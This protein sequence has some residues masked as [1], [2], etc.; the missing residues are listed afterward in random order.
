LIWDRP[1]ADCL[2][3]PVITRFRA[4]MPVPKK[5]IYTGIGSCALLVLLIVRRLPRRTRAA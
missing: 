4:S 2:A 3:A 5:W 1:L